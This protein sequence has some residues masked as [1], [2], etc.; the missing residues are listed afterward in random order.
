M[1]RMGL[2]CPPPGGL[3]GR[4]RGRAGHQRGC[5]AAVP[6]LG[7]LVGAVAC[8]RIWSGRQNAP[9]SGHAGRSA[10]HDER[11]AHM[12][13]C[14][15]AGNGLIAALPGWAEPLVEDSRKAGEDTAT[16]LRLAEEFGR[17]L[18]QPGCGDTG[19][20]WAVLA[21]ASRESLTVGR[22]LEAHSDAL[23]I[24]AEVGQPVPSGTWGVFAAEVAPHR[25]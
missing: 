24:L 15:A 13:S 23:A 9:A 8:S 25:L 14:T 3:N 12:V 21:A 17:L 4:S 1:V 7:N 18:P 22:V 19:A 5:C 6:Q 2:R 16:A 20:R 10:I 11:G